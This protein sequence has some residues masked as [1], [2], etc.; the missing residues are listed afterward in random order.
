M[1]II[2][3]Y[4]MSVNHDILEAKYRWREEKWLQPPTAN[5]RVILWNKT[6]CG[7][8]SGDMESHFTGDR[9]SRNSHF[10][11][12]LWHCCQASDY[13]YINFDE[14]IPRTKLHPV[15]V[16][17]KDFKC[18]FLK[19]FESPLDF[20]LDQ[21]PTNHQPQ[22]S[23]IYSYFIWKR[24]RYHTGLLSATVKECH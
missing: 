6:K 7:V 13:Y 5:D 19:R 9:D 1:K 24:F 18:R 10:P 3:I 11:L 16:F 22:L 14:K 15:S 20:I 2:W 8:Q 21:I 4:G 23:K 17:E 12:W